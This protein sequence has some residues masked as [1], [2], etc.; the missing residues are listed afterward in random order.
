MKQQSKC[1]CDDFSSWALGVYGDF[2][3]NY[4][5]ASCDGFVGKSK[6][7]GVALVT[8]HP[9]PLFKQ[10]EDLS[11]YKDSKNHKINTF[12]KH[13]IKNVKE[14][15]VSF[16][17]KAPGANKKEDTSKSR[18]GLWIALIFFVSALIGGLTSTSEDAPTSPNNDGAL[19]EWIADNSIEGPTGTFDQQ[20]KP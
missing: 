14:R 15:N 16:T 10:S 18:M 8:K 3:F 2:D 9:D 11:V 12:D 20:P 5:C 17:S 19:D 6:P 1:S 13:E 4:F 7:N